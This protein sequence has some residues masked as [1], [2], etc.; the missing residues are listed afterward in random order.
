[1]NFSF[2]DM[3]VYADK[4]TYLTNLGDEIESLGQMRLIRIKMRLVFFMA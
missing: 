2:E 3:N 1:M 4:V